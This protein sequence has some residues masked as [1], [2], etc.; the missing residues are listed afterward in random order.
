MCERHLI[1]NAGV[2]GRGGGVAMS[3]RISITKTLSVELLGINID[4]Q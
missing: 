1:N 2:R 3:L 4:D